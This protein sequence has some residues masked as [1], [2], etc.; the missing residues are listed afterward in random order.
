[1]AQLGDQPAAGER[2]PDGA[3]PVGHADAELLD[4]AAGPVL[5]AA[6]DRGD[7]QAVAGSGDGDVEQPALL[8]QQLGP[9]VGGRRLAVGL[10]RAD[11]RRL[12]G[13]RQV[14]GTEQRAPQPQVGPDALLHA[15]HDDERPL[16]ALAGVGGHHPDGVALGGALR[17]RV[18]GHLLRLDVVDEPEHRAVRQPVDVARGR[19]EQRQHGV[20]RPVGERAARAAGHALLL[21]AAGQAAGLPQ[22]PQDL[23]GG[24]AP[25]AC[26]G[27]SAPRGRA[28]AGG[29][30]ADGR[31][32]GPAAAPAGRRRP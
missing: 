21:Q 22:R 23:L 7:D 24:A 13:G 2:P 17:Q 19:V 8:G 10:E 5:L 25:V 3:D 1:M 14:V 11:L 9:P 29:P 18:A 20:E 26:H 6:R 31:R 16:E 4:E 30:S 28:G 27:R 12:G 32:R 15:G